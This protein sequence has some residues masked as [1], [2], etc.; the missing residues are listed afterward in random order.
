MSSIERHTFESVDVMDA[1]F[2][3]TIAAISVIPFPDQNLFAFASSDSDIASEPSAKPD[4]QSYSDAS[5]DDCRELVHERRACCEDLAPQSPT[6]RL[7]D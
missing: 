1:D 7:G 3:G 5:D 2:P 6:P 4:E